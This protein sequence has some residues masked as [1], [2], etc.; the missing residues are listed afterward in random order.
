MP[1]LDNI[2]IISKKKIYLM[3]L[4]RRKVEVKL[5]SK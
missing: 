5:N 1:A 3:E 2:S 4:T